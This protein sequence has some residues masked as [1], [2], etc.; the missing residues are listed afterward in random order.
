MENFNY[1]KHDYKSLVLGQDFKVKPVYRVFE[2][3][4]GTTTQI[5]N[6]KDI[7]IRRY[8]RTNDMVVEGV[9]NRQ[10]VLDK[11]PRE[12]YSWLLSNEGKRLPKGYWWNG[13]KDGT[14]SHQRYCRRIFSLLRGLNRPDIFNKIIDSKQL[15]S[16]E[17]PSW[18]S[19]TPM[20]EI[21]DGKDG[22]DTYYFVMYGD[23]SLKVIE[24]NDIENIDSADNHHI[25]SVDSINSKELQIH[26]IIKIE[27]SKSKEKDVSISLYTKSL[28]NDM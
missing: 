6:E 18:A 10:E 26:N 24:F 25:V 22:F 15:R 16:G 23:T 1:S 3:K 28:I 5:S 4:H 17:I 27:I 11:L 13:T 8:I 9:L 7:V 20:P 21:L 19:A 12:L 2:G 14:V